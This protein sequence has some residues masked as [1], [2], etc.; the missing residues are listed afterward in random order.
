MD[1]LHRFETGIIHAVEQTLATAQQNGRDVQY[2]LIDG[3]R[4]ERLLHRR[5]P[6]GDVDVPVSG[7]SLRLLERRV[8]ACRDEME[9]RPPAIS[10]GSC[11]WWVRTNTGA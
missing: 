10:I 6:T 2:E 3:T 7:G 4:R 8:E 1:D 11:A 5:G 9:C